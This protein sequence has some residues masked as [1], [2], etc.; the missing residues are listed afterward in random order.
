MID[1]DEFE[2]LAKARMPSPAE[3][4]DPSPEYADRYV[5]AET[6]F[7]EFCAANAEAIIAEMRAARDVVKRSRPFRLDYRDLEL[8]LVEYDRV[9]GG[10][11]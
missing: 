4:C 5:I 11:E 7:H 3:C 1:L 8:A 2:R 10:Q 9:T 6:A